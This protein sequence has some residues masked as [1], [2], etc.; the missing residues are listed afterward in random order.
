VPLREMQID[1]RY[2][3]V[4]MAEQDLD[5]AQVGAGFEQMRSEAVTERVRMDAPVIEAG[6]FGGNLAGTPENLGGDWVT[7]R[8]PAVAGEEPLPGLAP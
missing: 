1:G 7:C 5:G 4:A 8:V 2:F 6:A 3:E